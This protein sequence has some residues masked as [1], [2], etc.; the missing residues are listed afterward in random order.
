MARWLHR[1]LL[2]Q[3]LGGYLLFVAILIAGRVALSAV[4]QRQL[5]ADVQSA[6]L[7]LATTVALETATSMAEA[8]ASVAAL[9][10]LASV[11]ASDERAMLQDFAT[12]KA[13]R[14]D[15]DRVYWLDAAGVMRV[16][17]PGGPRTLGT[18]YSGERVYRRASAAAAPLVE[19]G[20]VDLTTF[21]G[22]VVVAQAVRGPDGRLAGVVATNLLLDDLSAPLRTVVRDQ[23]ARGQPMLVSLVDDRGQLIATAER[24]RLL[25]PML[26]ELPGLREAL[27]GAQSSQIG[28]GPRGQEWLFSAAPVP[29]V[30]W[31]VVVQRPTASA[32]E[33]VGSVERWLLGAGALIGL[34]G[35]LLWLVLVRRVARPLRA[36]A[37]RYETLRGA[38]AALPAPPPPAARR[39]DEVGTLAR[40]LHQLEG[41]VATR[42]NE[43]RTLLETSS[44]V[45]GS[46][47]PGAV[48]A[49]LIQEV[50]RLVDLQA[51]AVLVP[52]DAGALRV[53][54]SAGHTDTY[55]QVINIALDHPHSPS[56]LALRSAR[57]VQMIAGRDEPFPPQ[58]YS[59]GFRALLAIPIVSRHVGGVVLL[60]S[61]VAPEPFS[62]NEL[63]LLL[64][65]ANYA[66]LAWEHA[67][68]YERSDERL[69]AV[70]Q[71]NERLYHEARQASEFKSTLLAAVGHELRT[72]LAAIK[73]HASTLLQD[74]VVWSAE[75][76][77]HFLRTISSEADRL[78]SLVSSLL[79][80]SR[81]E[82]GLLL[83]RPAP[84]ALDDLLDQA[85]A[86]LG[87][88]IPHL[89]RRVP[90][91]LPPLAVDRARTE[92]V[93]QNLLANALAY[94][95]GAV[96]VSAEPRDGRALVRVRNDGPGLA[97]E[98]LDHI[99]ERFYRAQG[100]VQRRSGGTGLGLAICKAFVEAHGGAI[101]AESDGSGVTISLTLPLAG[102]R[103]SDRA[104]KRSSDRAIER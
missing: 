64:T 77:R 94:G 41:D 29:D 16:S 32:L 57:P 59:E 61:R 89:E 70:A 56:A 45:V 65:F 3:L 86:R 48:A 50:R 98:E 96:W 51:A 66:T 40:T 28:P 1:S 82:A 80:L 14:P 93:L 95:A 26:D 74:D 83:L 90:P 53:L 43:L 18:D 58:S 63:S 88:P 101:W 99:F 91:D 75:D 46:L 34:G 81:L 17:V 60:V 22:V 35:L 72:P 7:A 6:D 11:R 62:P 47:D 97:P 19:S 102:E 8:R 33:V 10:G 23:A 20:V 76:Q 100:G 15:L 5:R 12:F 103:E 79:D 84:W 44:A 54:A 69:R 87:Q 104:I 27:A 55:E 52:T 73:G 9:A 13:A 36:L 31:A 67:V 25:Q 38:P 4:V 92:V 39:A 68:L 21:N 49:T 24:E 85:L 30:G 42:L 2:V 78:A 71:E 37:L